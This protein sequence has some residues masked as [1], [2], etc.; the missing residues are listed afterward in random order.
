M[1]EKK[2]QPSA[3]SQETK[4]ATREEELLKKYNDQLAAAN[5]L[6]EQ[7]KNK[8]AEIAAIDEQIQKLI[9][10]QEKLAKEQEVETEKA[11]KKQ[12]EIEAQ[13][14][15]IKRLQEESEKEEKEEP[16]KKAPKSKNKKTSEGSPE[17]LKNHKLSIPRRVRLAAAVFGLAVLSTAASFSSISAN[18]GND[19]AKKDLIENLAK[20]PEAKEVEKRDFS[21][22]VQEIVKQK[23]DP[24]VYKNFGTREA[25]ERYLSMIVV[26]AKIQFLRETGKDAAADTLEKETTLDPFQ[27]Q[28]DYLSIVIADHESGGL[29]DLKNPNSSAR[30][31]YQHLKAWLTYLG[32]NPNS[33]EDLNKFLH[34]PELQEKAFSIEMKK[35]AEIYGDKKGNLSDIHALEAHYIGHIGVY[36]TEKG[37]VVPESNSISTNTLVGQRL[38]DVNEWK[39]AMKGRGHWVFDNTQ[40]AHQIRGGRIVPCGRLSWVDDS[41][42]KVTKSIYLP[43]IVQGDKN[44]GYLYSITKDKKD[45]AV[46][47]KM[48]DSFDQDLHIGEYEDNSDSTAVATNLAAKQIKETKHTATQRS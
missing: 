11:R 7:A 1:L 18:G 22:E 25:R 12:E 32:L 40:E 36:G 44:E 9:K 43:E 6:V 47:S 42:Y 4:D 34:S 23:I 39:E 5:A 28:K 33:Q 10:K 30:G 13:D 3:D 16:V 20:A 45:N 29:H 27:K 37:D 2:S 46:I 38:R 31:K 24:E 17:T 26:D 8:K 21:K 19:K 14:R 15:E 35:L 48:A 41:T